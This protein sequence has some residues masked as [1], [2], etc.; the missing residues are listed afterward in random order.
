MTSLASIAWG[1]EVA[2][3]VVVEVVGAWPRGYAW[4]DMAQGVR[5]RVKSV[6][7]SSD[8]FDTGY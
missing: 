7:V 2:V 6:D 1:A 3:V 5:P 4:E 8:E